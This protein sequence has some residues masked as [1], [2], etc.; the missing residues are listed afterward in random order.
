[1]LTLEEIH[2]VNIDEETTR[3][4]IEELELELAKKMTISKLEQ[5][6]NKMQQS[7]NN[8]DKAHLKKDS[9]D[10][11]IRFIEKS[12]T[13]MNCQACR[14]RVRNWLELEDCNHK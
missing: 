14:Q 1:M 12:S 7:G 9:R 10:S 13:V 5:T 8:S 2:L 4:L 3:C 6:S 11:K